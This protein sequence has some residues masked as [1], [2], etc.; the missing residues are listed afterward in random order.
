MQLTARANVFVAPAQ[1]INVS[2]MVK[3]TAIAIEVFLLPPTSKTVHKDD[4]IQGTEHNAT[5]EMGWP[6]SVPEPVVWLMSYHHLVPAQPVNPQRHRHYR[7]KDHGRT[8]ESSTLSL[9]P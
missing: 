5:V 1:S 8:W 9:A 2:D 6:F 7:Y 4:N 3:M